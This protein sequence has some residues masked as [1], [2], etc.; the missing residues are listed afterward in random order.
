MLPENR[1][2]LTV[3]AP[4]GIIMPDH[5]MEQ[6]GLK[7][8]DNIEVALRDYRKLI[9]DKQTDDLDSDTDK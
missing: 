9:A 3:G 6:L 7:K 1:T 4:D 2:L 8:G 5:V